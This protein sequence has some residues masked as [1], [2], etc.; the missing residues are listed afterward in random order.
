MGTHAGRCNEIRSR[1]MKKINSN[2]IRASKDATGNPMSE[3]LF[4]WCIFQVTVSSY[5]LTADG[6]VSCE[7]TGA[8]KGKREYKNDLRKTIFVSYS[9]L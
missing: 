1:A 8:M 2:E 6:Q 5:G 7:Q 9:I 4:F 3:L